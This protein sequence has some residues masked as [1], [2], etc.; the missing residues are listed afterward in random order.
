[1]VEGGEQ[2][3]GDH[4]APHV[5]VVARAVALQVPE[6][7]EEVGVGDVGQQVVGLLQLAHRGR[8]VVGHTLVDRVGQRGVEHLGPDVEPLAELVGGAHLGDQLGRDRL[9]VG[10]GRERL[11]H[12]D[13]PRPPLQQLRRR[14][15]EVPLGGDAGEPHPLL[16]AREHVV[17]QVPELVEQRHHVRVLHQRP[18]EVAHQHPLGRAA[19]RGCPARGR[20]GR[21]D[22]TSPPAGAGRGGSGRAVAPPAP[23]RTTPRR[24]ARRARRRPRRTPRRRAGRSR[25]AARRGPW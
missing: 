7:R 14:L 5:G 25:R 21:R 8:D 4:Q 24:R 15:H 12:V 13:V 10:V 18:R 17:H 11:Q 9:A 16:V 2:V 23:R 20:T 6:R 22:R 19:G 3:L 1:M